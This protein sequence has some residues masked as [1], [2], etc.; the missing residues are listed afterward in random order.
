MTVT[1]EKPAGPAEFLPAEPTRQRGSGW[2]LTVLAVLAA[3]VLGGLLIIFTDTTAQSDFGYF[4]AAPGAF[5][6]DAWHA[7]SSAYQAMFA[8][9]I[10]DVHNDGTLSGIF[11]PLSDTADTAAPL[12]AAGLG[13]TLAFRSGLFNIGAEG[14]IVLGAFCS[15]YVGFAWHLP[16]VVHMLAAIIA[17]IAGG[18]LWGFIAGFLKARTGA[19]EVITTIMLNYVALFGLRYLLSIKSIQEPNNPQAS[20]V[21]EPNAQLPHLFGSGLSIDLGIVLALLA[22]TAVW[23]LMSRSTIGFRLRAVGANPAAARTAGMSVSASTAQAM[24]LAGALAGLAGTI[25]ALGGTTSY[26][27]TPG[28]SSNYGFDAITVA[29]LGRTRPWPTVWAGL[30]LGALKAGGR[31]MQAATASAAGGGVPID[32]VT[33]IEAMIVIFI[34]APRLI[35]AVVRLKGR[36]GCPDICSS[37]SCWPCSA[38]RRPWC[39]G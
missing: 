35:S 33:V 15:G 36:P 38:R 14:Q 9:A 25:M 18:G 19:H 13:I 26:Q 7:V 28:I 6:G 37:A 16:V 23:W 3:L 29:L 5:F 21:I 24:L 8:G 32:I 39:S 20:K 1:V 27:I 22:A 2:L 34:A 30:L 10:Y 17:G 12:I 11:G 31:T 4:F